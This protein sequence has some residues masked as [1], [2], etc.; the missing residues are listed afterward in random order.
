MSNK[1]EIK[2]TNIP[3]SLL[4]REESAVRPHTT[5]L[6]CDIHVHPFLSSTQ[7]VHMYG[8]PTKSW[9]DEHTVWSE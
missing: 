9:Y 2:L 6:S 1:L 7:R 5:Y 4:I 8:T 3:S